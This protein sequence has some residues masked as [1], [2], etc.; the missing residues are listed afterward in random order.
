MKADD[1]LREQEARRVLAQLGPIHP[2]TSAVVTLIDM[3][4]RDIA[5]RLVAEVEPSAIYRMQGGV[6]TLRQLRRVI[7]KSAGTPPAN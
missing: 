7:D 3:F 2:V 5:D 4:E 6:Q 1:K